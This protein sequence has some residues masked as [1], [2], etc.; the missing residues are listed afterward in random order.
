[1]L[2]QQ[3]LCLRVVDTAPTTAQSCYMLLSDKQLQLIHQEAWTAA[4]DTC[5]GVGIGCGCKQRLSH[6]NRPR[7]LLTFGA[8][9]FWSAESNAARAVNTTTIGQRVRGRCCAVSANAAAGSTVRGSIP[10]L[11]AGRS[12]WLSFILSSTPAASVH[13]AVWAERLA[14]AAEGVRQHEL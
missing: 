7:Q 9:R 6:H 2:A 13:P 4:L 11:L 5:C 8:S 10:F 3:T 1:L 14:M 12:M